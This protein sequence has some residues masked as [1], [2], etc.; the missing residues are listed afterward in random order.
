MMGDAAAFFNRK[1][2]ALVSASLSPPLT[3]HKS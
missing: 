2:G 1:L 3:D